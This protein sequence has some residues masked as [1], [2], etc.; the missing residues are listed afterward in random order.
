VLALIFVSGTSLT[1]ES[2]AMHLIMSVFGF[3]RVAKGE[4]E[5]KTLKAKECDDSYA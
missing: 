5:G 4:H 3:I 1:V 2:R